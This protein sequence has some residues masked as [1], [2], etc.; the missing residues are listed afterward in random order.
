MEHETVARFMDYQRTRLRIARATVF[1]LPLITITGVIFLFTRTDFSALQIAL[2]AIVCVAL[3]ALSFKLAFLIDIAQTRTIVNA[4]CI[5]TGASLR[6]VAAICYKQDKSNIEFLL[7][8]TSDGLRWTFP[9][10]HVETGESPEEAATREAKEEAGVIGK[11]RA[12]PI[13]EYSFPL[14]SAGRSSEKERVVAFLLE[15]TKEQAR[16]PT[17]F[18]PQEA[19]KETNY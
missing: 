18:K 15:V 6:R 4:Y 1:N 3:S 8:R 12:K 16:E 11:V 7:V 10:G 9:K 14:Q 19:K 5:I 13:T 2:F 17:W